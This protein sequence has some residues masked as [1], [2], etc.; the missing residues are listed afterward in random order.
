MKDLLGEKSNTRMDGHLKD[1]KTQQQ[2]LFDITKTYTPKLQPIPENTFTVSSSKKLLA[3]IKHN[4]AELENK[5]S[6]TVRRSNSNLRTSFKVE[7]EKFYNGLLPDQKAAGDYFL[8]KIRTLDDADQLLMLLH[9]QPGS[10]KT[11]FIERIRDYTNI[12]M[13]ISAS[14][15]IAGMSLGGTTLDWLMGFGYGSKSTVD[16]ET[17]RKRFKGTELLIIDEISMIG[18]KK[19]L[20]VDNIL[21]R[22]FNDT[23]PFGGLH[24][25]LVGDY[26]Q[27]PAIRQSTIIDTMVNSTRAHVDH[28]DLEIQV[29]ALF[30]LFKKYELRGFR[31]SKDCKRLKKLLTKFRDYEKS[32]PTLSEVDLKRIGILNERVLRKDRE[33]REATVLVTTRKERDVINRRAGREWAR[34]NGSP[35][36]W[37]YQRPTRE[38][39]NNLEADHYAHSM[40]KFCPGVRAFYIPGVKCMLKAN[41]LPQAGYANGSQGRMIGLVHEDPNYVLPNGFPGEMIMIPPP[42]F[43]IMEVNHVGKEKKTSILPCE[44][45]ATEIEYYRDSKK[46]V[47]RCWSNMVVLT[48]ALTVHEMQGQT[49]RRVILLLGRLP[50]MNVGRIS[51]SLLYVALSRTKKLAHIK[52]FPTGSTKYYHPMYFAHLLKLSMP[53]NLKRWHRSYVDHTWDRNILRNEHVN[54]VRK[55]ERKLKQLGEE[56]A[57]RLKQAELFSLVKEMRYK[58]TT[59]DNK[60]TLFCKLKEHMVKRL[61]WKTLKNLKPD[62]RKGNRARKRKVQESELYNSSLRQS[63]RFRRNTETKYNFFAL[64][65]F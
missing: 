55:V 8:R 43:I 32:E 39:E 28:S 5:F 22:V 15:G 16:L 6:K 31:R 61:L 35:I 53:V 14:S 12:R 60:M 51:W 65:C 27:L 9:G 29:E 42:R 2:K 37:W 19:L 57:K 24:V 41:T 58:A 1:V 20:R 54:C 26:A 7:K 10:G 11:F 45:E 46:F 36:F 21:K 59:R 52:M 25:L 4:V 34:K 33:F 38:M 3:D 49:L 18:C 63:N 23:K 44:Q 30:G 56:K 64:K 17:L 48:F 13:K 40:S 50:G 62:V 47:Y